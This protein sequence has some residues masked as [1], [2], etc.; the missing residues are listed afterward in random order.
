MTLTAIP[1]FSFTKWEWTVGWDNNNGSGTS[2][3]YDTANP[4][5]VYLDFGYNQFEIK[6]IFNKKTF[7]INKSIIDNVGG[8]IDIELLSGNI[9]DGKYEIGSIVK[10]KANPD[11]DWKLFEW[12]GDYTGNENS[13]E[14]EIKEEFSIKASFVMKENPIYLDDNGVTIKAYEW[15]EIGDAG[16][17][18][19]KRYLIID[20]SDLRNRIKIM[21][22]I[23]MLS[24]Q[25]F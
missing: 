15:S 10:I 5:S 24:H 17:L 14:I 25:K 6:A 13:F 2:V 22:I 16:L 19:N 11:Q 20:E 7:S 18:N 1:N 21:R 12:S 3:S 8:N 4:R 9:V 23:Q